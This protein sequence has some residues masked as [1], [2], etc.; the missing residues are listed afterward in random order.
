MMHPS[1][2]QNKKK[3]VTFFLVAKVVG[4]KVFA[5]YNFKQFSNIDIKQLE[6]N[7]LSLE[8]SFCKTQISVLFVFQGK[9]VKISVRS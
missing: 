2:R 3:F 7:I 4:Q 9:K 5:T 1:E 8:S 6:K